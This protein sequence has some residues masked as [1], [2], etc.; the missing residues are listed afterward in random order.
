VIKY[1][2]SVDKCGAL[3]DIHAIDILC[4]NP[5]RRYVPSKPVEPPT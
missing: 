3:L 5:W 4:G 1:N 2:I